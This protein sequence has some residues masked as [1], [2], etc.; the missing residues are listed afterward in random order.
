MIRDTLHLIIR[1]PVLLLDIPFCS[2]SQKISRGERQ[3]ITDTL[4]AG[5]ILLTADRLFPLWKFAV[6]MSGSRQYSHVAMYEGDD[7]IIEATTFHPSG[8]GVAH[9]AVDDFLSGYKDICVLRPA[10]PSEHCKKNML[11][12]L[13]Q[14]VGKPYDYSF[15]YNSE[16][17]I[18]CAKLAGKAISIAGLSIETKRFLR[19]DVYLPD[20]FMYAAGM[21]TVFCR[22]KVGRRLLASC[23]PFMAVIPAFM[24]NSFISVVFYTGILF[25][26][27]AAGWLQHQKII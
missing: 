15:D 13:S 2:F 12:W 10:Y 27:I 23:L 4:E 22:R 14:Q 18:Y 24:T 5:D 9:T 25:V 6:G 26:L 17:A 3:T 16:Q 8:Y 19:R 7:R 11:A 21:R 1:L 20:T